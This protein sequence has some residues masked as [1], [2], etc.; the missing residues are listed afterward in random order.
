MGFWD[1]SG[2][3]W[4]IYK[5][6]ASRSRQCS[7]PQIQALHLTIMRVIKC[8]YVCM[9]ALPGAQPTKYLILC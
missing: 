8:L 7:A 9:Y 4:T 1:G 3:S 2:I 6:S 5:C